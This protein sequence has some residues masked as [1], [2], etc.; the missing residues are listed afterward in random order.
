MKYIFVKFD[1]ISF[2]QYIYLVKDNV[3]IEKDNIVLVPVR[4]SEI[5]TATVLKVVNGTPPKSAKYKYI[6]EVLDKNKY[7]SVM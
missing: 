3:Q 4:D 5:K 6:F 1:N 2:H 7:F